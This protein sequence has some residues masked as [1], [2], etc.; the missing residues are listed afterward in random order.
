MNKINKNN[1]NILCIFV[2]YQFS[3]PLLLFSQPSFD[4][5]SRECNSNGVHYE[6]FLIG[7]YKDLSKGFDMLYVVKYLV[8]LRNWD[9]KKNHFILDES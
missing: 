4:V 8:L 2:V 3:F 6:W 7:L 1:G 5:V 9:V